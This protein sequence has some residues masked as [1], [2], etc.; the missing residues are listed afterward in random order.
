MPNSVVKNQTQQLLLVE[1]VMA[2][3]LMLI[4][5]Q[6]KKLANQHRFAILESESLEQ[7]SDMYLTVRKDMFVL[8]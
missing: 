4:L 2:F 5:A 7:P 8:N 1:Y 3:I 6:R